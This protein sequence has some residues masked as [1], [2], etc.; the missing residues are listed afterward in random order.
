MELNTLNK[1]ELTALYREEMVYD[2]P[3]SERGYR[4]GV[5]LLAV[6]I[7][8]LAATT[9]FVSTSLYS[10]GVWMAYVWAVPVS[11]LVLAVFSRHWKF[12]ICAIVFRSVF[13]WTLLAAIYLHILIYS[14]FT[15][16][17][18]VLFLIGAPAQAAIVLWAQ[19]RHNRT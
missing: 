8:W 6:C 12:R 1:K 3:K 19:I 16:N 17:V 2:F 13:C 11:A 9:V 15:Y 18:W 5:E 14:A 10:T 7:V 4:I